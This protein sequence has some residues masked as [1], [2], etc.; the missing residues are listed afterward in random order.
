MSL[1]YLLDKHVVVVVVVVFFSLLS[2][3][4]LDLCTQTLDKN[5]KNHLTDIQRTVTP[6]G[7]KGKEKKIMEI[8]LK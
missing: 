4:N 6:H 5:M 7:M 1:I 3:I 8:D 2:T